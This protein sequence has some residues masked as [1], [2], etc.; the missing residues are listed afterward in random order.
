MSPVLVSVTEIGAYAAPAGTVT[1]N[2]FDVAEVTA[3]L[4]EPK[5]TA[6]DEDVGLKFEPEIVTEEPTRPEAGENEVIVGDPT[7]LALASLL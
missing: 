2:E 3:A 5:N 1:V 4:T 6:L 7:G